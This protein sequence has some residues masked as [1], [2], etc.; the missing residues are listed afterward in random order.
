MEAKFMNK[1]N[2]VCM[3]VFSILSLSLAGCVKDSDYK[4]LEERVATLEDK[5]EA[6]NEQDIPQIDNSQSVEKNDDN[7]NSEL[8]INDNMISEECF[9]LIDDM[10]VDDIIIEVEKYLNNK[11]NKGGSYEEYA[12]SFKYE[13][14][15]VEGYDGVMNY[16]FYNS[17][18]LLSSDKDAITEVVV[19][20]LAPQM[21]GSIGYG[22]NTLLYPTITI[23]VSFCLHDYDKAVEVYDRLFN[24]LSPRYENIRDQ[25]ET[26]NWGSS[27]SFRINDRSSMG[28]SIVS[29]EKRNDCY[30]LRTS[31]VYSKNE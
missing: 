16:K 26:T 5:M 22:D 28:V 10:S 27:G 13:P 24:E 20:G 14:V 2:L 18:Y 17:E 30:F 1:K 19:S 3:V 6:M 12:K 11:P 8:V 25:R 31:A 29:M 21:D 23:E 7:D 15:V 4:A 9:F